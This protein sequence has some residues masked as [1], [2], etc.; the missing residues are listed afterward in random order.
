M[1]ALTFISAYRQLTPHEK[2]FVDNYVAKIERDC[3]RAQ[4]R[5]SNSLYRPIDP[6][7]IAQSRGMLDKPM[8]LAAIT[9]RITAIAQ[10]NELTPQR[11][12]K[13][14]A[15]IAFASHADYM[16]IGEDGYPRYDLT[17]CTPE[18]LRALKKISFKENLHGRELHYE[19]H[20]KI[21]ALDRLAKYM[22]L[23]DT[24]NPHWRADN[25]RPV[26]PAMIA[27]NATV[28]D[29]A[30]EYARLIEAD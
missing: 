24:D 3:D 29:A 14:Y 19:T 9:E 10:A 7:T 13:E 1:N 27:S 11:V 5:I 26:E 25:A 30:N 17:R 8:V 23:L 12:I 15:L 22:G 2:I 16:E 20:D 18:Q 6:E 21:A 28:D 4:E